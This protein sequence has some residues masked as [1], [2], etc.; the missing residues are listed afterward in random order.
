[1][2]R[3]AAEPERI[4]PRQVARITGLMLRQVQ[5][6]GAQGKIPG[7]AKLDTRWTF[8]RIELRHWIAEKE[9]E[10]RARPTISPGVTAPGTGASK[11]GFGTSDEAYE[12]AIGLKR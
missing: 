8:D 4:R 1:M 9:R 12:R 11:W 5:N 7:A 2:T 6:L 3:A 10:A